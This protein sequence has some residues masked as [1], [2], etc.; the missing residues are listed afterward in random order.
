MSQRFRDR[1]ERAEERAT[2][3]GEAF[4]ELTLEQKD[5]YFDQ[6]KEEFR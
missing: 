4:A 5:A 1:V 2:A 6:A 3:A